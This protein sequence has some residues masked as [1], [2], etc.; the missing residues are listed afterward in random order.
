MLVHISFH[1]FGYPH[2]Y[3]N[4]RYLQ[5]VVFADKIGHTIYAPGTDCFTKVVEVFGSHIVGA[6]GAIDR[7][8]LGSI[9]FGNQPE[10]IALLYP[11]SSAT[12]SS[13][14]CHDASTLLHR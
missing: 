4:Y 11:S 5:C 3:I 7:K 13:S 1:P 6:D 10:V 2:M 8:I 9:V 14:S 12:S